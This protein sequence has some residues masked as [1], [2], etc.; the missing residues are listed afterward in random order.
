MP[1]QTTLTH[2][3]GA[4]NHRSTPRWVYTKGAVAKRLRQRIANPPSPV[5]I[6][7]A[8]L[9]GSPSHARAFFHE[10]LGLNYF[11][12][13]RVSESQ[14][15]SLTPC[16]HGFTGKRR[17]RSL[18]GPSSCVRRLGW[19]AILMPNGRDAGNNRHPL[20]G[21][22]RADQAS[23]VSWRGQGICAPQARNSWW[24]G[25]AAI[26]RMAVSPPDLLPRA[27]W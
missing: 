19:T 16:Q 12:T 9:D 27:G 25:W 4:P 13:R 7:A 24:A 11:L 6:R 15:E 23:G 26:F 18:A 14:A 8:P 22:I 21:R 17:I 10:L 5:R 20:V 1:C 2:C 3:K